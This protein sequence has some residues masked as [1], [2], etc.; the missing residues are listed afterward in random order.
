RST[1]QNS[2]ASYSSNLLQSNAPS[3]SPAVSRF[4]NYV[5]FLSD[6]TNLV[7]N[8]NNGFAD[9]FLR[10]RQGFTPVR[11][12]V[13]PGGAQANGFLL[14]APAVSQSGALVAFDCTASNLVPND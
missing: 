13:G 12:I 2:R 9:V 10:D 4:G 5:A 6:G 14:S 1:T 8:D 3:Y 11:V 7:P